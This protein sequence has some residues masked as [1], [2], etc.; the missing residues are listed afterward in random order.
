V[1][2]GRVCGAE[3]VDETDR[4]V[5]WI[6]RGADGE[7]GPIERSHRSEILGWELGQVFVG[8]RDP[9]SRVQH[10]APDH[11]ARHRAGSDAGGDQGR[12]L[13]AHSG[14][15]SA[16]R[17]SR[18]TRP[19]IPGAIWRGIVPARSASSSTVTRSLPW[20]PISTTSSPGDTESS[21]QSTRIWSMVTVPTT[22][23]GGPPRRTAPPPPRPPRC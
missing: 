14:R 20:V 18:G 11:T 5:G 2:A 23:W 19:P 22:G 3:P 10:G 15:P 16:A 1:V 21:P 17:Y 12:G 7:L 4:R 13:A 9:A 8:L 6:A